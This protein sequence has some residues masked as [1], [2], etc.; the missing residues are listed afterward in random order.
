MS[1]SQED[2]RCPALS[3][4]LFLKQGLS[5][6]LELGWVP[7]SSGVSVSLRNSAGVTEMQPCPALQGG[8]V[9][10]CVQMQ[11]LMHGQQVLLLTNPS[12]QSLM[13]S[14]LFWIFL[15]L[16]GQFRALLVLLILLKSSALDFL[17]FYILLPLFALLIF[18]FGLSWIFFF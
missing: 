15:L 6:T 8:G 3:R 4:S 7:A 13:C 16:S 17:L 5:L 2:I 12:S 1:A 10:V 18:I 9:G 11:V 14:F